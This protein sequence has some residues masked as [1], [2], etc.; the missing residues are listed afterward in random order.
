M[1]DIISGFKNVGIFQNFQIIT[2]DDDIT[3]KL[4]GEQKYSNF[5]K[6]RQISYDKIVHLKVST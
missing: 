1:L 3:K 2:F 5:S 6:N 4:F